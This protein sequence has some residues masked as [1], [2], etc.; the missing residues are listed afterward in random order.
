[1]QLPHIFLAG[2]SVTCCA[3]GSTSNFLAS[4]SA[5]R[6]E[7]AAVD[8]FLAVISLARGYD[9]TTA[10]FQEGVSVPHWKDARSCRKFSQAFMR[11]SV[12][13]SHPQNS[14]RR[15]CGSLCRR[16]YRKISDRTELPQPFLCLT[17]RTQ[18]PNNVSAARCRK[19]AITNF[20]AG[21][22]VVRC[23]DGSTANFLASVAA[24]P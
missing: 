10:Y 22:S 16:S 2:V 21:V 9:G 8:N 3:E 14:D 13:R 1:M 19:T 7:E 17:V 15:A 11:L 6:C 4:V 23:I 12:R 24:G 20:L 5:A 18:L